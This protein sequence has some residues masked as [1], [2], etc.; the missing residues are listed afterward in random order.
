MSA[1]APR[2]APVRAKDRVL[3]PAPAPRPADVEVK[4][5]AAKPAQP[6]KAAVVHNSVKTAVLKSLKISVPHLH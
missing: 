2:T 3:K 5:A 1:P 6:K 4:P